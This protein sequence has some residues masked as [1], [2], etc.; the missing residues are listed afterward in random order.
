MIRVYDEDMMFFYEEMEADPS[1]PTT[2]A[3][4]DITE[5]AEGRLDADSIESLVEEFFR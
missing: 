3:Y 2:T 5:L 1:H 4:E